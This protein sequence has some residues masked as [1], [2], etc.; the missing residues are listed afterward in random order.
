MLDDALVGSLTPERVAGVLAAKAD[1]AWHLHELTQDLD[2]GMFVLFSS[3]AGVLGSP[4]QGSYA[5]AN[6]FLDAL[7]AWRQARGLA[8]VSVAWG[9][10][11][12]GF[13]ERCWRG[14][15]KKR[16]ARW[17]VSPEPE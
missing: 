9:L 4:G 2:L 3:A 10:W 14:H 16:P 5:A 7:A 12:A 1:A 11:E 17:W 8:G 13:W 6:A 15:C